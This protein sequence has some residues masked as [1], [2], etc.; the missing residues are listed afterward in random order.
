MDFQL[1]KY[2]FL[3]FLPLYPLNNTARNHIKL[4]RAGIV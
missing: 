3:H 4:F 1:L 2:I